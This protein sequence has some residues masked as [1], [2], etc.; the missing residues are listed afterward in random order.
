MSHSSANDLRNAILE[1]KPILMAISEERAGIKINENVWSKKEILGHLID[2][3]SNNH[4]RFVRANFT[5]DLLFDGYVQDDWVKAQNYQNVPFE[6][7]IQF[8]CVYNFHLAHM[9]DNIESETLYKERSSHN[10]DKI[11]FNTVPSYQ[12]VTLAYF[13][14]DYIEHLKHHLSQIID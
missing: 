4:H 10:L 14:N 12:S 8:W 11:A 1:A 2:S 13:I 6:K 7:I 3:A 5:E 9:I